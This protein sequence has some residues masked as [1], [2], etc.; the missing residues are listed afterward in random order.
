MGIEHPRDFWQRFSI[1][2]RG[3]NTTCPETK[4]RYQAARDLAR[5]CDLLICYW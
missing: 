5:E 3:I 2:L 1:E 4:E